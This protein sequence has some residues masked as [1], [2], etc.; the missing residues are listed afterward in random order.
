MQ[1]DVIYAYLGYKI[2]PSRI[3]LIGITL[4]IKKIPGKNKSVINFMHCINE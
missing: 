3:K 1:G 4:V 2:F